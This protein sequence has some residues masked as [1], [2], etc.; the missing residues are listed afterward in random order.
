VS[1]RAEGDM[2]TETTT[3]LMTAEEFFDWANQPE[4]ADRHFELE[5]GRV[6]EMPSPGE[7]HGVVCWLI[8]LVVGNYI[9][10]RGGGYVCTNDTGL[11][12]R[13][14]PDT[15]RGPDL[16][17]FLAAKTV[18]QLNRGHADEVPAAVVEVFSPSDKPGQINRRIAQYHKRG[19]PLVWIVYPEDRTVD[20][21]RV[22]R[23]PESLGEGDELIGGDDLPGFH[24]R[25]ADLFTLPGSAPSP[26][27]PA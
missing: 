25:V 8:G 24:C 7:L 23:S 12:V 19:V 16:M 6:V 26:S 27:A 5:N 13:R 20:V 14:G 2:A 11:I 9:F 10:A 17:V 21:H 18:D 1:R 22:G 3:T 4:R 15:V